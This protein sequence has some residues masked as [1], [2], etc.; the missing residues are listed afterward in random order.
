MV[1]HIVPVRTYLLVFV[2]LMVLYLVIVM[3]LSII[4]MV[5][6]V[7]DRHRYFQAR[8]AYR[9]MQ[10]EQYRLY[11]PRSSRC[12]HTDA[13]L[14]SV[15]PGAAT[16]GLNTRRATPTRSTNPARANAPA[17]AGCFRKPEGCG[18]PNATEAV[19]RTAPTDSTA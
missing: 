7:S 9:E 1:G 11:M 4:W 8:Q 3:M 16:R 18:V 15:H 14:R 17:R 10:L 6:E 12:R 2:S 19:V 13:D 5:G